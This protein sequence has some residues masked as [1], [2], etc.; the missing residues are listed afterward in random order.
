MPQFGR[1]CC[2][3]VVALN[4]CPTATQPDPLGFLL[5]Q[6]TQN[7]GVVGYDNFYN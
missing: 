1:L 2:V 3:M 6:F 5:V 7:Q 4:D